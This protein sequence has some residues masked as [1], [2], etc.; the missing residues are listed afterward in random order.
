MLELY[1]YT[2]KCV[3]LRGLF[4]IGLDKIGTTLSIIK[5]IAF[6]KKTERDR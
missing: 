5:L 4:K 6:L 3:I 2:Y 1:T